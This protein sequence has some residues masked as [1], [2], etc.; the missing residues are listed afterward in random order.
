MAAPTRRVTRQGQTLSARTWAALEDAYRAAGLDPKK[1]LYVTKGAWKATS[2]SSGSTHNGAGAADLR[3]WILPSSAQANEC[4]RLVV[5]LRRRGLVAWYRGPNR[6]G[7]D[8]HIHVIHRDEP[9]IS[10]A[11]AFQVRE[12]QAGRDGLSR[13]GPDYHPR[14][15]WAPF[16]AGRPKVKVVAKRPVTRG[17]A[18]AQLRVS[19]ARLLRY[20]PRLVTRAPRPGQWITV[21][22][23]GR[24]VDIKD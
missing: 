18:A 16:R 3:V 23:G 13:G 6:G 24:V 2:A 10:E 11:A 17:R 4:K 9:G 15:E 12:Y 5:E 1:H 19:V 7:F 21:P 22:P 8:P 14:P 20:N